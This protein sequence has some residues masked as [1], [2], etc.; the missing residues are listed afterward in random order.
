MEK[1]AL[2]YNEIKFL[3]MNYFQV[4]ICVQ[5]G[6]GKHYLQLSSLADYD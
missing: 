6:P 4:V 3:Q 1:V 5:I 2:K